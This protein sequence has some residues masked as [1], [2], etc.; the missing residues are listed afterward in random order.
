M[1]RMY[2]ENQ[3]DSQIKEVIE[4]GQVDNA[5][6]IYIHPVQIDLSTTYAG[7]ITM[8]I[9]NNDST[10]FTK[11]TFLDYFDNLYTQVGS[12]IRIMISG[13]FTKSSLISIASYLVKSSTTY[14]LVG[15]A[16]NGGENNITFTRNEFESN[17]EIFN[18]G[19]NKIN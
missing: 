5:K 9:F 2:S 3:L 1:R 6:P 12:T 16:L 4:S 18:D 7:K 10:P 15:W 17:I 14:I 11:T 8:L 13:A 19:V